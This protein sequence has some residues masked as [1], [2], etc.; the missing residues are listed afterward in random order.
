MAIP[1]KG[2]IV[3][4]PETGT[5]TAAED[6]TIPVIVS[7]SGEESEMYPGET[8]TPP[9]APS[10][11]YTLQLRAGWNMVSLPFLPGDPSASSVLNDVG[12]YQLVTR[13]GTGYVVVTEFELGKGYWLLVLEDTNVTITG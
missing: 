7:I 10:R 9:D 6:N 2:E 5:Y 11:E 3:L 13:S 12:Y 4:D 8:Y 1:H